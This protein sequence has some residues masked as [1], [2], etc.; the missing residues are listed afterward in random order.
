MPHLTKEIP[1][2]I[3]CCFCSLA[4]SDRL[5]FLQATLIAQPTHPFHFQLKRPPS[6]LHR[7]NPH[8]WPQ[9]LRTLQSTTL[10]TNTNAFRLPTAATVVL[11]ADKAHITITRLIASI[12]PSITLEHL[13]VEA[14]A[15]AP[16]FSGANTIRGA[17][18]VAEAVE[19][20][21]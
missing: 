1:V 10:G 11:N 14:D 2:F 21:V 12:R 8:Q 5:P 16:C 15:S 17:V 18:A 9:Y 19:A 7:P 3:F 13:L 20:A 4:S 6:F